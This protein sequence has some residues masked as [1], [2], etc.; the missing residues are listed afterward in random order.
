MGPTELA[1]LARTGAIKPAAADP[2]ETATLIA[3]GDAKLLDAGNTALTTESRFDLAYGAAHAFAVAA[4]RRAGYRSEHR[5][6]VFQTTAHTLATPNTTI[7][8]L[9]KAHGDRN[10]IEY[11][12]TMQADSRLVPDLIAAAAALRAAL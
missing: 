5:V 11:D 6:T 2:Q 8:V 3:T 1:N 4:L 7:R 12:G 9:L 10:A